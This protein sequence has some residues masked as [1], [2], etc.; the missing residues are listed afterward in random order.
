MRIQVVNPDAYK[1]IV[2][3]DRSAEIDLKTNINYRHPL[4]SDAASRAAAGEDVTNKE[5][6]D[7]L[8]GG[9]TR[10]FKTRTP[11]PASINFT[12]KPKKSDYDDNIDAIGDLVA[13]KIVKG[14][15]SPQEQAELDTHIKIVS[16]KAGM[17]ESLIISVNLVAENNLKNIPLTLNTIDVF[18]TKLNASSESQ[19]EAAKQLRVEISAL[20]LKRITDGL[21]PEETENLDQLLKDFQSN[22]DLTDEKLLDRVAEFETGALKRNNKFAAYTLKD[23]ISKIQSGGS[24][25]L[26]LPT[27]E[28]NIVIQENMG[29]T[30]PGFYREYSPTVQFPGTEQEKKILVSLHEGE[31]ARQSWFKRNSNGTPEKQTLFHVPESDL[32]A[33]DTL[34]GETDGD[35]AVTNYLNRAIAMGKPRA[36][37]QK[38]WW[39]ESRHVTSFLPK[40]PLNPDD[41]LDHDTATAIRYYEA[42]KGRQIDIRLFLIEKQNLLEKIDERIDS[43]H[44]RIDP[45]VTMAVLQDMLVEDAKDPEKKLLSPV[46][47]DQALMFIEDA[48]GLGYQPVTDY[49]KPQVK[50]EGSTLALNNSVPAWKTTP[51]A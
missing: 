38:Q 2:A 48:K 8:V 30:F 27:Q 25:Y 1:D 40:N 29:P 12:A 34:A 43:S 45:A 23:T 24:A 37:E 28:K 6:M 4:V 10:V 9:P 44:R 14:T 22:Q 46:Q 47:K 11:D 3:K 36:A 16:E 19:M 26:P 50:T 21:N 5:L 39:L 35:V 41:P 32:E 15:L 20:L 42:T 18:S 7:V 51:A 31:H 17:P 33:V 13:L 49:P